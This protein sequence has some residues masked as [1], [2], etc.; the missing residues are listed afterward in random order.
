MFKPRMPIWVNFGGS[1]IGRCWYLLWPFG[2]FRGCWVY[3]TA[4]WYILRQDGIFYGNLVYFTAIWYICRQFGIFYGTLVY[5]TAIWYILRSSGIFFSRF[6]MLYQGKSGNPGLNCT[7]CL[8]KYQTLC[9][10]V[11][12]KNFIGNPAP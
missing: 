10:Y 5:L 3:F 1:C 2:P 9:V 6:G 11:C 7:T 12:M 8:L 4:I